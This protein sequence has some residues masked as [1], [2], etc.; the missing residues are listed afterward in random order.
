MFE[1]TSHPEDFGLLPL[2]EA[3]ELDRAQSTHTA[4]NSP[5][6]NFRKISRQRYFPPG[7]LS[8]GHPGLNSFSACVLN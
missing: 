6:I 8:L 2:A 4:L 1:L 7:V 5:Y 3:I